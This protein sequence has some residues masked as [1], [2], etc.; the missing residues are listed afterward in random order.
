MPPKSFNVHK[1]NHGL[2][3]WLIYYAP[4]GLGN[5][6]NDASFYYD[7]FKESTINNVRELIFIIAIFFIPALWKLVK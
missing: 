1:P 5:E 2:H 7:L 3:P 4:S 6:E